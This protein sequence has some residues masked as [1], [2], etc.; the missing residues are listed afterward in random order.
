MIPERGN[1]L[2]ELE[3]YENTPSG[4]IL[5]SLVNS[6]RGHH[7]QYPQQAQGNYLPVFPV[8][9]PVTRFPSPVSIHDNREVR[10]AGGAGNGI[11][12]T[13]NM[14]ESFSSRSDAETLRI[15]KEISSLDEEESRLSR[16]IS[17]LR[18][19]KDVNRPV[20]E[21]SDS[22]MQWNWI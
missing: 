15:S 2:F 4:T 14:V 5:V 7:P 12:S 16:K 8:S 10:F 19:K 17:K 18:G 22:Q 13:R 21:A 3:S 11:A 6:L 20:R 1:S 9:N